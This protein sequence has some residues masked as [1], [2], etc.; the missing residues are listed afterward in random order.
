MEC[1]RAYWRGS[2]KHLKDKESYVKHELPHSSRIEHSDD[3]KVVVE[4]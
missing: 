3:V 1:E 4:E 2:S